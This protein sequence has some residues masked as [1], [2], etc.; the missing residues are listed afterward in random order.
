MACSSDPP[1]Y[2]YLPCC[3]SAPLRPGFRRLSRPHLNLIDHGPQ[4]SS[5]QGCFCSIS[6]N[7]CRSSIRSANN[8]FSLR[9]SSA[10]TLIPGPSA[11]APR[12]S[13]FPETS[14]SGAN[15]FG[16]DR[17]HRSALLRSAQADGDPLPGSAGFLQGRYFSSIQSDS[18]HKTCTSGGRVSDALRISLLF[19]G[20]LTTVP[21]RIEHESVGSTLA[22]RPRNRVGEVMG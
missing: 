6:W 17:R 10:G 22:A 16:A 8:Y 4:L 9:Y 20:H 18:S 5:F 11:R 15:R 21:R 3:G 1:A 2:P 12:L 7:T 19:F 13:P 14:F